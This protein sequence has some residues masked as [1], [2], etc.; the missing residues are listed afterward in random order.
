M[1]RPIAL[2]LVLSLALPAWAEE[3]PPPP[4]DDEEQAPPPPRPEQMG[5]YDACFGVPR[6]GPPVGVYIEAPIP[7]S[8]GGQQVSPIPSVPEVSGAKD[9]K[10]WLVIAV[11]AVAVLPVVV[12]AIDKPAERIVLQRFR[13]PTFSLD[14]T[15][16]ADNSRDALGPGSYGF[17]STRFTFGVS[18]FA[19]DFQYDAAP[20]AVSSFAA[21]LLLRPTPKQHVE[22]GF[23]IG[24]RRSVL[25]N[26]LVEGLEIGFPHRYALWRDGLRT[27]SLE[28]RPM[29]LLGSRV[30]PNLEGAFLIPL[31][32]VLHLRVGGRLYTFQGDLFWGLSAGLGVTL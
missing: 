2:A 18:H 23:A 19:T 28:L 7:I 16:G 8:G 24:Y 21:H 13:C 26:R 25:D 27:F 4:P 29:L 15:G 1:K 30:E 14:M 11:V 9:D 17:F 22:G 10:A 5:Y 3:P 12:Y 6:M 20:A 31:A 32:Q